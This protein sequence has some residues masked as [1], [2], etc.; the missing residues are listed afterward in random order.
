M[1]RLIKW[2]LI[3][4]SLVL[5]TGPVPSTSLDGDLWVVSYHRITN[6]L[7]KMFTYSVSVHGFDTLLAMTV[8]YKS[9]TGVPA[10]SDLFDW[11]PS[12]PSFGGLGCVGWFGFFV[13]F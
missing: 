3:S 7:K 12:L 8:F 6:Q 13:C 5:R 1:S 4:A 11:W 2:C 10:L 9:G